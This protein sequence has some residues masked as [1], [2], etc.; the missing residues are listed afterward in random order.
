MLLGSLQTDGS[1]RPG[2]ID[3][4]YQ[5][6]QSIVEVVAEDSETKG[7][8]EDAVR[9]YD[10]AQVC[11]LLYTFSILWIN[12]SFLKLLCF[13]VWLWRFLSYAWLNVFCLFLWI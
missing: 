5:D 12:W 8:F 2:A 9:L 13:Q 11:S 4:F 7:H 10:L 6:T 3:K 1:R